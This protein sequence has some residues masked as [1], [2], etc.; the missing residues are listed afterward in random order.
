M[1]ASKNHFATI[2][3]Y[4][5]SFPTAVQERLHQIRQTIKDAVPEA[6]EAIKYQMPT[7]VLHGNL[8]YFAAW[9]RHIS[10]YPIT[11]EMEASIQELHD[12]TTSG[13]GTIQFPHD[14]PLPL[15]LIRTIVG[16]RVRENRANNNKAG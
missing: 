16:Y 11:A 6:E 14:K 1:S 5:Q 12:Y 4:I 8:I 13:K 3:E 2:D 15:P 7:F 10:L 9:K